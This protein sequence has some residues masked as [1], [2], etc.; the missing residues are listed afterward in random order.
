MGQSH[1]WSDVR[2]PATLTRVVLCGLLVVG[3]VGVDFVGAIDLFEQN[4]PH[5]LVWEGHVRKAQA[6]IRLLDNGI[7]Q[8]D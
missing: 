1:S 8:S 7:I 4:H 6:I 2:V 5:E 3:L